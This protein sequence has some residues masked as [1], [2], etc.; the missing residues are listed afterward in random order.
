[1]RP[2]ARSLVVAIGGEDGEARAGSVVLLATR[3]SASRCRS[4]ALERLERSASCAGEA[5]RARALAR[6]LALGRRGAELAGVQGAS[7][8]AAGPR[9]SGGAPRDARRALLRAVE[10][11]PPRRRS[12]GREGPLARHE[13]ARSAARARAQ[14]RVGAKGQAPRR[15]LPRSSAENP[16]RGAQRACL[17]ASQRLEARSLHAHRARSLLERRDLRRMARARSARSSLA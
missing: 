17:R 15:A 11:P 5:P 2:L 7:S 13:G 10:P 8:V 6:E 14:P 12:G 1:M 4:Q 3:R 16:A 9:G